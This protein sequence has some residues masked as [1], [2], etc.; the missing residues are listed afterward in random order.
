VPIINLGNPR[1]R[2]HREFPTIHPY[3]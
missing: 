2:A 1:V 3:L